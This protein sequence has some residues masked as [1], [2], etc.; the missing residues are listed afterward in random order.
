METKELLAVRAKHI[1]RYIIEMLGESKSGH[2]GG[3]LDLAEIMAVLYFNVMKYD[4]SDPSWAGRDYFV[5]SKRPR[6]PRALRDILRRRTHRGR[7]IKNL[8]ETRFPLAG[9][10]RPEKTSRRGSVNRFAGTGFW[11][12]RR[13]RVIF[14]IT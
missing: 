5:L 2:P 7:R 13:P 12:C 11:N 1:R 4:F 3:S 10:S 8:A 9:A 6:G 14:K